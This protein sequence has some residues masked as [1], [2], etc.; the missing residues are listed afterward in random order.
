M[1]VVISDTTPI[2]YLIL[3][4]NIDV[5]P[6]L[7]GQVLVPPAVIAELKHP[8]TPPP[9]ATWVRHLPEWIEVRA[10]HTDLH[11]NIGVGEDAAIALAV[12]LG[13][14]TVLMDDRRGRSAA[15]RHGLVTLRTL[16]ILEL[17]HDEGLLDFEDALF[18]LTAEGFY[19]KD[20]VMQNILAAFRTRKQS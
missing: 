1:R 13:H 5:L 9:V 15:H 11:L 10:P 6:R 14:V 18:R 12:E 3:I 7:F 19:I 8:K 2:N 4:G 16:T 17:A 20:V